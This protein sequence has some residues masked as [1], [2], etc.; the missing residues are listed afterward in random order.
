MWEGGNMKKN[1]IIIIVLVLFVIGLAS[2]IVYDKVINVKEEKEVNEKNTAKEN[3]KKEEETNEKTLDV[4]SELVQNLYSMINPDDSNELLYELY[5]NNSFTDKY[6]IGMSI[7]KYLKE[8]NLFEIVDGKKERS[9]SDKAS[10][11]SEDTIKEYMQ[12]IFG[13]SNYT[14]Q[15]KVSL[16]TDGICFYDYNSTYK[17]YENLVNGCDGRRGTYY[18]KVDTAISENNKIYIREKLIFVIYRAIVD[19][20]EEGITI[21]SNPD[22]KYQIFSKNGSDS[23]SVDLKNYIDNGSVYEYEFEK[24]D[25]NYILKSIKRLS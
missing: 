8:N 10:Y 12:K 25:N 17:R 15:D 3:T 6:K 11:I 21:Y 4:N 5:I 16:I 9:T 22:E 20:D 1:N 24:L 18:R 14:N 19:Y 2:Y 23:S 7:L 13:N